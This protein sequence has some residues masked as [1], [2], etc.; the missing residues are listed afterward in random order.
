[1]GIDVDKIKTGKTVQILGSDINGNEQKP[2]K[3]YD[4]ARELAVADIL[5][6][7]GLQGA[8][9]VG[10]TAVRVMV[11]VVP[12]PGLKLL[13]LYNNSS[14]IIYWGRTNTVTTSTGTPIGPNDYKE[15]YVTADAAIWVISATAGLNTR[16]TENSGNGT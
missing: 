13:T 3:S 11:G 6:G 15:W 1:M 2:V 9:T 7:A 14:N 4:S 16:I 10:L 12:I 8:L 5:D